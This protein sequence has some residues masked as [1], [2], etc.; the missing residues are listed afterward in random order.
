MAMVG[1]P[2]IA[3]LNSGTVSKQSQTCMSP[4]LV[5]LGKAGNRIHFST[6]DAA[7]SSLPVD[8]RV[9]VHG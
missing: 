3:D 5:P 2:A 8:P 6:Y 1:T 4:R 9:F 7:L